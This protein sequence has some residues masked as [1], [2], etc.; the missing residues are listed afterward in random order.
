MPDK[1]RRRQ[2]NEREIP[3]TRM[4]MIS[5]VIDCRRDNLRERLEMLVERLD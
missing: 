4:R 3:D 5:I 1:R 2:A